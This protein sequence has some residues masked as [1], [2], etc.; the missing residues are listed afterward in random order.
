MNTLTPFQRI[1]LFFALAFI[2][3]ATVLM[4]GCTYV[5]AKIYG[6]LQVIS[7]W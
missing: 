3:V 6:D 5:D 2:A 7:N 4:C 1:Q